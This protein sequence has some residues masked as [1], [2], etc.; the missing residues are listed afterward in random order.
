MESFYESLELVCIAPGFR[1]FDDEWYQRW[2]VRAD[3]VPLEPGLYVVHWPEDVA[4]RRFDERAV[5]YGPFKSPVE[6]RATLSDLQKSLR[7]AAQALGAQAAQASELSQ[8]A[9]TQQPARLSPQTPAANGVQ[10]AA[11]EAPI[12]AAE[13]PQS[14]SPSLARAIHEFVVPWARC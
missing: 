2:Y 6:A 7:P 12:A 9:M 10:P 13:E 1:L 5:Y 4:I 11:Q 3:N 8:S 14:A